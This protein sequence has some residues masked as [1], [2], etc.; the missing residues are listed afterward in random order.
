MTTGILVLEFIGLFVAE[1]LVGEARRLTQDRD[2]RVECEVFVVHGKGH[3]GPAT[4]FG[5]NPR[6]KLVEGELVR[7]ADPEDR[8]T[9]RRYLGTPSPSRCRASAMSTFALSLSTGSR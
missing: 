4:S 2:G 6:G 3:A 9:G 7:T 5:L 8:A 1:I